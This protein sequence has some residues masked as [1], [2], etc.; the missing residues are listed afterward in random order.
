MSLYRVR[1][2]GLRLVDLNKNQRKVIDKAFS[3]VSKHNMMKYDPKDTQAVKEVWMGR[4]EEDF[5]R[6]W[7]KDEK[8]TLKELIVLWCKELGE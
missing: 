8:S 1:D 2:N 6:S 3:I 7:F 5:L 4:F